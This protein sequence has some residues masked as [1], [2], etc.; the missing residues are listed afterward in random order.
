VMKPAGFAPATENCV[1]LPRVEGAIASLKVPVIARQK[2]PE[3]VSSIA[4]AVVSR[5]VPCEVRREEPV[6]ES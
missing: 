6:D 1:L 3:D 5:E 2:A 4:D